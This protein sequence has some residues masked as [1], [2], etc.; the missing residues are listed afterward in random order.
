MKSVS[1]L[2]LLSTVLVAA[3]GAG[4]VTL[5][6]AGSTPGAVHQNLQGSSAPAPVYPSSPVIK[7]QFGPVRGYLKDGVYAFLGIPFGECGSPLGLKLRS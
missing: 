2:L 6:G 3:L 1:H 4:A 5:R 7:T